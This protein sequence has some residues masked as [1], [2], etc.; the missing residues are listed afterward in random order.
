L[1]RFARLPAGA[2]SA[3]VDAWLGPDTAA[4]AIAARV[5]ALLVATKVWQLAERE[6]MFEES[7]EQLHARQDPL[8]E[9]AFAVNRE[10]L[11][12]EREKR[13]FDGALSRL[14]PVWRRAEEA[15]A[16][17]P[18]AFDAN[19]TFRVTFGHVGG[20]APRDGVWMKPL[21]T[22][23]GLVE[24]HTGEE[25]FAAPAAVRAAA[26]RAGQTRWADPVLGD[27]PLCFLASA[28]TTGGNSGSPVLNGK[29]EL[30][31]VNFDRVWEN[32]AN[33][34][35]YNPQVAR[36]ISADVRYLLWYLAEVEGPKAAALLAELGI[37]RP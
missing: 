37:A 25:P 19:S 24:K 20:Y 30:V 27:V 5:E 14:R 7:V 28:D 22:L 8:L 2:R 23:A 32:V 31:G 10:I 6:A 13:S 16:P 36:N 12:Y 18:V 15:V 3:A 9:L 21:T 26:P 35:G 4:P 34:F 1:G 29:G 17:G 33:D 11:A